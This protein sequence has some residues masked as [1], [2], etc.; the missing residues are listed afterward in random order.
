MKKLDKEKLI[1][2]IINKSL[3]EALEIHWK[4][5]QA[6]QTAL[7]DKAKVFRSRVS[8]RNLILRIYYE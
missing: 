7:R 8:K 3:I 5:F 6:S 1:P 2:I 4:V